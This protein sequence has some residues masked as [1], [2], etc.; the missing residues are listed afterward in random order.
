MKNG[1]KKVFSDG[2]K[3]GGGI[4][5]GYRKNGNG[6]LIENPKESKVVKYVFKKYLEKVNMGLPTTKLT[7]TILK[8]CKRMGFTYKNG[9]ELKPYHIKY[10]LKNEWYGNIQTFG[11]WGIEK[12]QY[13]N[14]ISKQMYNKVK[15]NF[16]YRKF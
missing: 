3:C 10:F 11:D 13:P 6:E 16:V 8:G 12:H 15:N 14:I 2:K 7:Q 5:F 1:K 4:C 9:K